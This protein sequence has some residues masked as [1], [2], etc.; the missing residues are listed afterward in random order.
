MIWGVEIAII[1]Q[2][3]L[4]V[5]SENWKESLLADGDQQIIFRPEFLEHGRVD[6]EG[7]D[8][9]RHILQVELYDF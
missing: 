3:G 2:F 7:V 6:L 4:L 5:R 1:N 9:F 8:Q